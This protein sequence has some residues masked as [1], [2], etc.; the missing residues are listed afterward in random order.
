MS[1]FKIPII[2]WKVEQSDQLTTYLYKMFSFMLSLVHPH[3]I[4]KTSN[5]AINKHTYI[6]GT[7]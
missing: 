6:F 7:F 3:L 1:K 4:D 2:K 5:S